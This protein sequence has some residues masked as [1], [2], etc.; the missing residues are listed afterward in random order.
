WIASAMS[1]HDVTASRQHGERSFPVRAPAGNEFQVRLVVSDPVAYDR[2]YNVVANPMLW[3]IQHYLW[4]L[5]NAPDI[6]RNEIEAFEFGYNVVNEDLARAVVE[7]LEDVADPVVMVHDYHLYTLPELVRRARPDVFL[8]HFVH[9]PW[10][11]PDAWRVLPT[12]IRQELYS[13]LLANDIIG[14]HTR[15]YRR[16]FL[17]CCRDL[18]DLEVDF[19]R[20]LVR[21]GE[22]EIW[23][24][25]YP[26]PIDHRATRLLAAGE[27]VGEF[28]DELLRRRRDF[29]ILRVDRAD[30]SKNVL[31]GFSAFDLFLEQHPEFSERVTFIAQLMP[32]RTDVPEYAEYLEKIEALVAVVNHRHGTPDWM[33]IQLKLRDDL[34]E[35]MAAYKHYDVLL[36]NAM[37]DGMN[38]VAKEGPIVNERA[39]VSIL[40][41]N[42][43]AHEELGEYALSVNPFDIQ[44]LA[45]SIH[46]ALDMP[47]RERSRRARGLVEIVTSRDPGDWI[48]EQLADIKAKRAAA[49]SL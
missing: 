28:E 21:F 18:M 16:N 49:G 7:E 30:L 35:A 47:A 32:S 25:A 29:L 33:P 2:F 13:G 43:G 19:D 45:D 17:Q 12:R 38:L 48:D 9:I 41:E 31:R 10:T 14:F 8:H 20:G 23:V 44:E 11:Q 4:D 6:R 34:E 37:F 27:R 39:G 15:S 36:V 5:S 24:R 40:S 26:L 1:E 46:A 22:R 42:T 3:F